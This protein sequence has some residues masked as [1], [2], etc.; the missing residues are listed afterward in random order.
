M[1]KISIIRVKSGFN[2]TLSHLYIDG[3]FM[4]YLLEDRIAKVKVAGQTCI[5]EGEYHLSINTTAGMN[6]RYINRFPKLHEGMIQIT[7]IKGFDLVFIH[8]G[9][10]YS[11]TRGCPLTGHYWNQSNG[12]FEVL[13]SAFS[14]QQVYQKLIAMINAGNSA[15]TVINRIDHDES[16]LAA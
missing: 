3:I 14:Y 6:K 2:S 16:P 7:G 4:C 9:N 10:Y 8:I 1:N 13:Q 11:E 12:D 5:P 15:I